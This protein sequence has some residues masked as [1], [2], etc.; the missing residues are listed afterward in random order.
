MGSHVDMGIFGLTEN[1]DY[2]WIAGKIIEI[3]GNEDDVVIELCFNLLE[4]SRF[5]SYYYWSCA[6]CY[7]LSALMFP[8][9][10]CSPI[11]NRYRSNSLGSWTRI[12]R[13]SAKT[14][15]TYVSV[16]KRTLKAF[17]KNCWK[18]RS[19]N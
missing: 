13:S 16:P 4:G 11:S 12:L 7:V 6:Y 10:F 2:R 18:Q 17:P 15:G 14:C 19:L 5:V 8:V 1:L 3:L 9:S